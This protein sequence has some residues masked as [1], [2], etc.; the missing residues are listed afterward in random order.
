MKV[1]AGFPQVRLRRLRQGAGLRSL[2]AE[3]TLLPER[4]ILP[5]FVQE[6]RDCQEPIPA[7]PGVWRYSVDRLPA[8]AAEVSALGLGGV[9]LFGVPARKDR[10]GSGADDPDGIIQR[11]LRQLKDARPDLLLIVDTCLCAYTDHGHCGIIGPRGELQNDESLERLAAV[12]VSQAAA[13]ADLV[14]P[15]AML[16]GQ[17][18]AIRRALDAAG[19]VNTPVLSYAAKYASALYGPFREAA[20]SAPQ[21]GDRR[22]YQL[23]PRNARQALHEIALDLAEGADLVMVKPAL[24]ALDILRQARDHFTVPLLAYH[25]SG[26]YAMVR[27]A[28]QQGWLD[29]QAALLEVLTAIRRA[30]ADAIITYAAAQVARWIAR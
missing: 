22:G 18:A 12:A 9:I 19:Q 2:V 5:L 3:S 17:V 14:A 16:D 28:A 26:E 13:G 15:S 10:R 20:A 29:E 27:A 21:F 24:T 7:L 4:L 11:A 1:L 25:V 23:D 6:G 30:G 8:I